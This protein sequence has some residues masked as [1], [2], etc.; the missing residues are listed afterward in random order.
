MN[1]RMCANPGEWGF[2]TGESQQGAQQENLGAFPSR[3]T[4][5]WTRVVAMAH[6]HNFSGDF[7]RNDRSASDDSAKHPKH[8]WRGFPLNL[9]SCSL[10]S[11]AV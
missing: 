9:G 1:W 2:I 5:V 10:S 7:K 8:E 3:I 6:T 4:R 11:Y